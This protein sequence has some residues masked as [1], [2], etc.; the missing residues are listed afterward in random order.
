MPHLAVNG[1]TPVRTIPFPTWPV[2]TE[3]DAQAVSDTILS[4][5]W[6]SSKGDRVHTLEDQFAAFQQAK[7]GIAVTNGTTALNLALQSV[8]L[9]PGD[10]VIVPAYTFIA[11][12]TTVLMSNAVPVFVD[13]D[14]DTYNINPDLV[15]QAITPKTRVIMPV[16]F[17][18]LPADMER[19]KDIAQRHHLAI[20]EDAA[21]A[22]GAQWNGKGVGGIGDISG[23]SFQA[24]KN[25]NAG[26]GGIILT[27]NDELAGI[28]GSL[29]D[30][31]RSD[32]GLW[33]GHYR[34][35]GNHRMT[36]MQGALLLSQMARLEEQCKRRHENGDYLTEQLSRI[37]GISPTIRPGQA[38]RHARHLYVFRYKA[39]AFGGTSKSKFVDALN[40]EG[41][42]ASPG[43]SLPLYKQPVFLEKN[44]GV[45]MQEALRE[46]D[47][48]ALNLPE[49]EKACAD[50]A[51]WIS[52]NVLLGEKED[53]D[54]IVRAIGK[55]RE[56]RQELAR[57]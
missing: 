19:L 50:E 30:C 40:A 18:G 57:E 36:E 14:P 21:Q 52:Q 22:H 43:Y 45:Y 41:I 8:G 9:T 38:N 3:E 1:A 27:D 2:Y 54:D 47:F 24:S 16:H 37:A 7:H 11:T 23:F 26:E 39:D 35:A 10:E 49:T 44:F 29:A 42:P 13:I 55:I 34:L 17:A 51:I 46:I 20:V 31:G 28:A 53:M 5:K 15:E 6:G 12:A 33:Y 32:D 4:G 56:R 25:L 48:G